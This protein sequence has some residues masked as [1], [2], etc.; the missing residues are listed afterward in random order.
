MPLDRA[1]LH[2]VTCPNCGEKVLTA[3]AMHGN[4][5]GQHTEEIANV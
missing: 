4:V 1:P 2:P 3:V 5:T